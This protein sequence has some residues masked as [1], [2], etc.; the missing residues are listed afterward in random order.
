M[1]DEDD[2]EE[3]ETAP[4]SSIAKPKKVKPSALHPATQKLV[5]LLFDTDMFNDAMK[6]FEIGMYIVSY[7]LLY[8]LI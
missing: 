1:S 3:M 7:F 2:E 8:I 6:S 5:Q 4:V